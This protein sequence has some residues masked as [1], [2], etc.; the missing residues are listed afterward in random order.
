M[1]VT[2]TADAP[3]KAGCSIADIAAGMYAYSNILGALLQRGRSGQGSRIEIS[4]L[5]AMAEWMG[6]PLYYAYEAAEPP[7]RL[8]AS[9]ATIYPYG[10]FP[11]AGGETILLGLQN[12]REWKTFCAKVLEQPE[13]TE[14]SRFE[15]NGARNANREALQRIIA[16]AFAMLSVEEVQQRLDTAQIAN[17]KLNTMQDLWDH[18]QLRARGRWRKVDSPVGSI[19]AL[20]P[21]GTPGPFEPRMEAV[22][23]LGEHTE[24]ILSELGLSEQEIGELRATGAI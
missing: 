3:A 18:E 11:V 8:G 19:P 24:A 22:P 2:G 17:A 13:L 20:L 1:S 15:S 10:P 16:A 7:A 23:A 14:D 6:F 21:P 9:H 4:M 12:E 5:E